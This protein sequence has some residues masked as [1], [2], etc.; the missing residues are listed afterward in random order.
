MAVLAADMSTAKGFIQYVLSR[1]CFFNCKRRSSSCRYV[2]LVAGIY[3]R[4][5]A[6]KYHNAM[7]AATD[8]PISIPV[9]VFLLVKIVT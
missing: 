4:F 6:Y 3:F 5:F 8:V 2:R 7:A 1:F 9:F